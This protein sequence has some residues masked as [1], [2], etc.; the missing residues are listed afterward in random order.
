MVAHADHLMGQKL[1]LPHTMLSVDLFFMISGYLLH[2]RYQPKLAAGAAQADLAFDRMAR[3]LPVAYLALGLGFGAVLITTR[4]P[5][6]IK[7]LAQ[8]LASLVMLPFPS[9][10]GR[11]PI[12][13]L[14]FPFWTLIWEVWLNLFLIF[15]WRWI[16]GRVL[17]GLIAVTG[18]IMLAQAWHHGSLDF[19]F[20]FQTLVGGAARAVFAFCMGI[21]VSRAVDRG[22]AAPRVPT[23]VVLAG[24]GLTLAIPAP[25]GLAWVFET[26]SVTLA[27]PLLIGLG[28]TATLPRRLV[29][30]ARLSGKLYYG[31]YAFHAPALLLALWLRD[32]AGLAPSQWLVLPLGIVVVGFSYIISETFDPWARRWMHAVR[33]RSPEGA[34]RSAVPGVGQDQAGEAPLPDCAAERPG[35]SRTGKGPDPTPVAGHAPNDGLDRGEGQVVGI[36][37]QVLAQLVRGPRKLRLRRGREVLDQGPTRRG[38]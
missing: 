11:G 16:T 8:G 36:L 2:T 1:S 24:L 9:L 17:G 10:T 27:F 18:A 19:G 25:P 14:D 12:V 23:W 4:H 15:G 38:R 20:Q 33:A 29:G 28:A 35:F 31:V 34:A 22:W 30:A 7:I 6:G 13:P 37:T 32:R 5:D 21:I 26:A 3:I